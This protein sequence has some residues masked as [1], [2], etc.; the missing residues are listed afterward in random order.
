MGTKFMRFQEDFFSGQSKKTE[1]VSLLIKIDKSPCSG[2][3]T[4]LVRVKRA[5]VT[6]ET[7]YGRKT[8]D[9]LIVVVI[10]P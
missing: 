6:M 1:T 2:H 9:G 7:N 4:Y 3:P 8:S 5:P 10:A